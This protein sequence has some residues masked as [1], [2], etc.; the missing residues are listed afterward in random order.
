MALTDDQRGKRAAWLYHHRV[1]RFG[2]GE[3]GLEALAAEP[4]TIKGWEASEE[5]SPIPPEIVPHLEAIFDDAYPAA[6][7]PVTIDQ[8]VA[9]LWVQTE[10]LSTLIEQNA[11]LMRALGL[12]P[13]PPDDVAA[14]IEVAQERRRS[15][16]TLR[17]ADPPV[18]TDQPSLVRSAG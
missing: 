13:T 15:G 12:D 6:T 1:A 4:D 8:L 2:K 11:A 3:G 16:S 10:R 7:R 9:V 17:P 5:R 18:R 14:T